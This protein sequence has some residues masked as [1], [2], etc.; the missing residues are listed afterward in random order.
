M[1]DEDAEDHRTVS[2]TG[3]DRR[4]LLRT[5][6]AGAALAWVTPAI[7]TV[8]AASAAT[9]MVETVLWSDFSIDVDNLDT[10]SFSVPYAASDTL[11]IAY[12]ETTPPAP[13]TADAGYAT[14]SPLGGVISSFI[15]LEMDASTGGQ[16]VSIT[17]TFTT[18]VRD[19]NFTLLDVDLGSGNWQD[20]VVLTATE[21]GSPVLIGAGDFT[22]NPLFVSHAVVGSTDQFTGILDPSGVGTG[23]PNF[24]T[25]ANVEVTYAALVDT[26]VITYIA[27]PE[28]V[29]PALQQIGITD[30]T[31][32]S[33]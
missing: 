9:C 11:T 15:T 33:F 17:F 31:F 1:H 19:L 13:P 18:P 5:G 22:L 12:D 16:Q 7:L 6:A 24:D 21:S 32:C 8:D 3:I 20:R 23:V 14:V 29:D 30:F 25:D 10:S 2:P 4:T 28:A 26:L 27:M